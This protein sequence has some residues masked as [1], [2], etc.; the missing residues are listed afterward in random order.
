V[1]AFDRLRVR[2]DR[3]HFGLRRRDR[4]Q[5]LHRACRA[6]GNIVGIDTA[7]EARARLRP[8]AES[9]EVFAIPDASK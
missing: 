2:V 9:L 5:Q 3:T 7:L 1:R 6:R 4:L 8:Q